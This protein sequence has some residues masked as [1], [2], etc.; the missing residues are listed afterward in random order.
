MTYMY[1][2]LLID[3][4]RD[5][6]V[7]PENTAMTVVR[8]SAEA[9]KV[10]EGQNTWD[11]IWFDHDL[12][13][14]DGRIDTTM[15]VVDYLSEKSFNGDPVNVGTVYIHTSNPVGRK[16]IQASM[17]RFGYRTVIVEASNHF[18]VNH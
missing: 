6:K 16:Q 7:E 18:S 15:R 1:T 8:N 12:G 10:L 4:L 11:E 17:H 2:V 3:D 9:L 13:E 14:V 5:F